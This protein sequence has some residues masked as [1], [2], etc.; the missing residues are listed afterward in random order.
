MN[1]SP[2]RKQ[3]AG[4]RLQGTGPAPLAGKRLLISLAVVAGVLLLTCCDQAAGTLGAP[5]WD[6]PHFE[7]TDETGQPLSSEALAGKVWVA[8]FIYTHC[9]DAG[10]AYLMPKMKAL[11]DAILARKLAG[12]VELVSFTIDPLRDTPAVL[13]EYA[14]LYGADPHIW[15]FL[16]GSNESIQNMLQNDF[17]IGAAF[18]MEPGTDALIPMTDTTTLASSADYAVLHSFD[19]FLLIDRHS[20]IRTSYDGQSV[21][22]QEMLKGIRLLLN[23]R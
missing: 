18:R 3:V 2:T 14:A 20:T 6:V 11:Q 15:H 5:W 17:K 13:A 23:E 22:I 4:R 12:R 1:G 9:P 10:P 8:D 7:L 16:T 21:Q 19:R